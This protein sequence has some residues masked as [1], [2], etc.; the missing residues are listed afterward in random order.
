VDV[1]EALLRAHVGNASLLGHSESVALAEFQESA[2]RVSRRICAGILT[3]LAA[4]LAY[5]IWSSSKQ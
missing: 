3:L 4:L 1:T 5:L 2:S